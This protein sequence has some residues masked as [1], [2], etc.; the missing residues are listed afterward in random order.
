MN[1]EKCVLEQGGRSLVGVFRIGDLIEIMDDIDELSEQPRGHI[2]R[3]SHVDIDNR[4]LS[5][6]SALNSD[7]TEIRYLHDSIKTDGRRYLPE[8]HPKVILWDGIKYVN[9]KEVGGAEEDS[10]DRLIPLDGS[11]GVDGPIRIKF[12]PGIFRSGDYWTFTT[13]SNS[14]VEFLRSAKPMGPKHDYAL[15]ALIRKEIGKEIEIIEDL[16][17]T[18]QPLTNLRAIDIPYENG[19]KMHSGPTTV[20]AA[21]QR[22]SSGRIRIVPGRRNNET[23]EDLLIEAGEIYELKPA[24]GK[25]GTFTTSNF[26]QRYL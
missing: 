14:S 3:I 9:A 11:S 24:K 4:I 20:Q 5:W 13:R 21:I 12:D 25:Q 17:H 6:S 15:L 19:D 16:R 2:R 8:L 22:L 7:Q 26:F 23:I 18:F 10:S 1:E